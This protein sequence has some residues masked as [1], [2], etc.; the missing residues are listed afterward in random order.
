MPPRVPPP[1]PD[2]DELDQDDRREEQRFAA[3]VIFGLLAGFAV[4]GLLLMGLT[5]FG[6]KVSGWW[7]NTIMYGFML[8]IGPFAVYRL[9][10]ARP[11]WVET[12]L[13]DDHDDSRPPSA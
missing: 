9:T 11:N 10:K 13:V 3:P 7:S 8:V 5:A 4:S 1:L 6:I 12:G 2:E